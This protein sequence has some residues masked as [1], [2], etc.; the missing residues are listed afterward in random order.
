MQPLGQVGAFYRAG[1]EHD[2]EV[3]LH[4][5]ADHRDEIV[6]PVFVVARE[7][8]DDVAARAVDAA[9]QRGAAAER[10]FQLEHADARHRPG[11]LGRPIGRAAVGDDDLLG[12]AEG[13]EIERDHRS[14][15]LLDGAF[16]V[17]HRDDDRHHVM[18]AR[19]LEVD[20]GLDDLVQLIDHIAARM[21]AFH[22]LPVARLDGFE[23]EGETLL[24]KRHVLG[25]A[26]L[27]VGP[28]HEKVRDRIEPVDR[29]A[30][31]T[32]QARQQLAR[33][34]VGVVFLAVEIAVD[35]ADEDLVGLCG[36]R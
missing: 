14:Q 18:Q 9:P 23:R 29:D 32:A 20:L 19:Q 6:G 27:G 33:D 30:A 11:D 21:T 34:I 12:E 36:W 17:E 25:L 5:R 2:I 26:D 13:L 16:F 31:A 8:H 1:A 35:V 24:V 22:R 7:K 3:R 10:L 28:L 15:H 4:E